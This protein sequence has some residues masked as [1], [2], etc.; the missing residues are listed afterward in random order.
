MKKS[1]SAT[2]RILAV[3]ALVVGVIA[4]IVVISANTGGEDSGHKGRTHA[5]K[6]KHQEKINKK[7]PA[8]YTIKSEDTLTKIA[9]ETGVPV[10][11]IE[12]LNPEIDPQLLIAGEQ[13]KLK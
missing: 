4:L 9:H 13:I 1:S 3:I 10:G 11:K 5:Q 8:T 7:I 2:A 6:V 12:R